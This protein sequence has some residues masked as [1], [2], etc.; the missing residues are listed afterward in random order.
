MPLYVVERVVDALNDVG[1]PV[2]GSRIGI[3]GAAYKKDVDDPRESPSFKLM[4]LLIDRGAI[5]SYND[6]HIPVLPPMRHYRVPRL[7]SE[8]LTA[9]YLASQD[10]LLVATDH[11]AYDWDFIAKHAHLIVDSRN[12]MARVAQR[13]KHIRKA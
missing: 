4:E 3:L 2:R 10:C 12:A 11:S 13:Y 8:P 9:D 5:V 7:A 6:P 1:K